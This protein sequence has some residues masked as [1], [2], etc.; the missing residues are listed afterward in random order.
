MNNQIELTGNIKT[1]PVDER[2]W[3]DRELWQQLARSLDNDEFY[4]SWLDLQCKFLPNIRAGLVLAETE[5]E[6]TF[7][8]AAIWP[9][10]TGVSEA[11]LD[12]A[13][14]C[15]ESG[16]ALVVDMKLEFGDRL[17]VQADSVALAFPLII[18]D[19]V[20]CVAA[21][22]VGDKNNQDIEAL[23]RQL[24]WGAS[25][26][27]AF[28]LRY[29]SADDEATIDRLVTV[30]YMAASASGE[31]SYK[32]AVSS[33]VTE[34][35]SR[36]ACER[37][38]CGLLIGKHTKVDS[39]SHT[40]QFGKQMNLVNTLGKVMDE[41][42]EQN[43]TINYPEPM[44]NGIITHNHENFSNQQNGGEILTIPLLAESK[45]IGAITI[46][47]P[48]NERFD[49]DSIQM[50]ESIASIVGPIFYEKKLNDRWIITKIKDS[51]KRQLVR[52]FGPKYFGRKI[53]VLATLGLIATFYYAKGDF[54][55]T[56]DTILEG[57]E[58]RAVV[59]PY[60]GF[61]AKSIKRVGD[62]V[63]SGEVIATI[64]DTDLRLDLVEL[65][66]GQAQAQSQYDEA[67]AEHDRAKAKIMKAKVEQSTARIDL[68]KAKLQR[69]SLISP[70]DGIII[71]GDLSQSLGAA[72]GRG[73]VLFEIASLFKYR[74]HLQVDERDIAH[75]KPGQKVQVLL[76]A[77]TDN[78]I[79]VEIES[80]TPVTT[81]NEGRNLF[82]VEAG[83]DDP[84]G[85]LRPGMQG[86]SK[87][88]IDQ[89]RY[90]WIW[91]R[92]LGNWFKL[93]LWKWFE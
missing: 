52:L 26:L 66:S 56:A 13:R 29:Q 89:Q 48:A 7:S 46:E 34:F 63:K 40:G 80:I 92:E 32:Q 49:E 43:S 58:Q 87:I 44:G 81:V 90:I 78:Q 83:L 62:T 47:R 93:W 74:V 45:V 70:I 37:V 19:N 21:V 35:A 39:M 86:I 11:L 57:A 16:E 5:A 71:N 84:K 73:E 4:S 3:V 64:D 51:F 75:I 22:D 10:S 30:L 65:T 12:V 42:I 55:I 60:E 67:I 69:T 36:L 24:Q 6:K 1:Q 9:E 18:Q 31:G 8:P 15:L 20:V 54:K 72:I 53:F 23:M 77:L 50:C 59:S 33:F 2:S 76:S 17:I 79:E 88:H 82:R 25:W 61:I 85:L 27:E 68:V 28:F 38:S 14:S 91:T 41:A